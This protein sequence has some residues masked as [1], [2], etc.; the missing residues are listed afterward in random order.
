MR[1]SLMH[2]LPVRTA[3]TVWTAMSDGVASTTELTP[4]RTCVSR[5]PRK[6]GRASSSLAAIGALLVLLAGAGCGGST[7][8]YAQ[9]ATSQPP[10]PASLDIPAIG[11][12]A[13]SLDTFG[14]DNK[15]NY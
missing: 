5:T 8:S 9:P 1:E 11:V 2:S 13:G 15:G 12:H 7:E 4:F 14:L 6:R 3:A 10:Q